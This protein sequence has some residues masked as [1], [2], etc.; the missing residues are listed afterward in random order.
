MTIDHRVYDVRAESSEIGFANP[1]PFSGTETEVV[2]K[3][4]GAFDQSAYDAATIRRFQIQNN[5]PLA[6]VHEEG[7]Q[8][9]CRFIFWMR[10]ADLDDLSPIL[11]KNA[12]C[13]WTREELRRVDDSNARQ[14]RGAL[15]RSGGLMRIA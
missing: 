9:T 2:V 8:A 6:V 1:E 13:R 7:Q 14:R 12:A 11:S 5:T 15:F 10:I 4:V 3:N